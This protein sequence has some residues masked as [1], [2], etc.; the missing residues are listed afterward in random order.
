MTQESV[1]IGKRFF[2]RQKSIMRILNNQESTF[3]GTVAANDV[4]NVILQLHDQNADLQAERQ[5]ARA[6]MCKHFS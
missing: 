5:S 4:F 3:Q 6:L 1:H 2:L